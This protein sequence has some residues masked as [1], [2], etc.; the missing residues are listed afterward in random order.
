MT[1]VSLAPAATSRKILAQA[2]ELAQVNGTIGFITW[3]RGTHGNVPRLEI[4]PDWLIT[5]WYHWPG[6]ALPAMDPHD[7]GPERP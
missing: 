7:P 1:S 4:D 6:P 3:D 2:P 5:Y